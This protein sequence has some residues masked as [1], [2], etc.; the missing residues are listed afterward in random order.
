MAALSEFVSSYRSKTTTN[1]TFSVTNIGTN[2]S[3]VFKGYLQTSSNA[4]DTEVLVDSPSTS[5]TL[6]SSRNS[7]TLFWQI[8]RA[9][10]TGWFGFA[11]SDEN[12]CGLSRLQRIVAFFM[13]LVGA[14][15][16]FGT[17]ILVLPMLVLNAR[18]FAAL[19]TLGSTFFIISFGFLWGPIAYA[20]FLFSAQRRYVT[21]CYLS[22]VMLTLYT[23][24]W[25]Q[26]TLFTII[27]AILQGVS[28]FW[29]IMTYI[30]GGERGLRFI[31]S[32]C[33]GQ[34]RKQTQTMLPI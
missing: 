24:V 3:N 7:F 2:V 25:L 31:T 17:A 11:A 27:C 34:V 28:L 5:G 6:P 19:N 9:T 33:T 15:F 32:L 4:D 26:S 23:S 20:Q 10:G 29:Y 14:A 30:P 13:C 21:I 22:T 12:F 8:R 18:K 16:C 1:K